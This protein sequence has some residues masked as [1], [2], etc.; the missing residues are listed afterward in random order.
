MLCGSHFSVGFLFL[1]SLMLTR[2]CCR[3]ICYE[4]KQFGHMRLFVCSIESRIVKSD[5]Q[6]S[7]VSSQKDFFGRY[8]EVSQKWCL[9]IIFLVHYGI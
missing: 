2:S 8:Q 4:L 9:Y 5:V 7:H 6:L 1:F 3:D